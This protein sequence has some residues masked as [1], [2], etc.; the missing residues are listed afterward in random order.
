MTE[1]ILRNSAELGLEVQKA[2]NSSLS[3]LHSMLRDLK[4]RSSVINN[5][6]CKRRSAVARATATAAAKHGS[7]CKNENLVVKGKT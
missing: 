2:Q 5:R 1:L 6:T 3:R 7:L 4:S